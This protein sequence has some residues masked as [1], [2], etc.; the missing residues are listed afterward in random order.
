MIDKLLRPKIAL[1]VGLA[2][3]GV[4]FILGALVLPALYGALQSFGYAAASQIVNSLISGVDMIAQIARLFGP[5]LIVGALILLKIERTAA[6]GTLRSEAV[7]QS[8]ETRDN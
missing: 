5:M 7:P 8:S 3:T 2:F 1:W 6:T 4:S